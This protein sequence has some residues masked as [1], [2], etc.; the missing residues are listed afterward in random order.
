MCAN[1]GDRAAVGLL[2]TAAVN[3]MRTLEHCFIN[4]GSTP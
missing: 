2:L 1:S 4:Q 3:A